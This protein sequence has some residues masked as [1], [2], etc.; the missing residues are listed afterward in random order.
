MLDRRIAGGP[1]TPETSDDETTETEYY[2]GGETRAVTNAKGA[3]TEI[4]LDGLSR[5]VAT[6][7]RFSATTLTTATEYDGN[8]NKTKETD[9][10]GVVRKHTYDDLNRL[11]RR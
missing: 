5:P 7:T 6:R 10:R 8:G 2:P 11:T 1:T 4:T 9:R 3:R